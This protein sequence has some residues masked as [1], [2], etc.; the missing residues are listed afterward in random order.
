VGLEEQIYAY[1]N[2]VRLHEII[3]GIGYIVGVMG[4]IAL[5]KRPKSS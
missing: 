4:L 1:E 3:G 5:L 2:R